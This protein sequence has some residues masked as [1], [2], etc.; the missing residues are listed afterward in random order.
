MFAEGKLHAL[1]E[2]HGKRN[3]VRKCLSP[4]NVID[5]PE[6][7]TYLWPPPGGAGVAFLLLC[8]D[9][10]HD[11]IAG[12]DAFQNSDFEA[13]EQALQNLIVPKVPGGLSCVAQEIVQAALD[14]GKGDDISLIL[15]PLS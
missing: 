3:I 13:Q 2:D 15:F 4:Q 14:S 5:E 10:V 1:T 12:M 9:G 6:I 7:H 8:S 11:L